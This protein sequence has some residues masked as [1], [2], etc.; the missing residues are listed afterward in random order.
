MR[1]GVQLHP[2][3][4]DYADIRRALIEA[5][6]LGVDIVYNWDHFYPLYGEPDGKHF[7]AW[8]ML[9]SWAE[10]TERVEIGPLVTCN[11]YR[12]PQLLADMARTVDHVSE[13]RLILGLGSGWFERDYTEYG[14]EFGT[15][16]GRLRHLDAN[17]PLIKERL[18]KLNP[19]PMRDIPIL[20]GG[21]GE[22]VTL[23]IVAEHADI[24]HGFFDSKKPEQYTHKNRVLNDWCATVG[25]DP[26]AI[27][28]S[29]GVDPQRI[30]VADQLIEGGAQQVTLGFNGPG[31]D[32]SMVAEWL[33]WRDQMNAA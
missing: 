27:E 16:G 29:V 30:D 21:G 18:T 17:L 6:E 22:K 10:I 5:E 19:P 4:A 31:F 12:N 9:A 33:A 8:T 11:S 24:W 3:H 15:A 28:R 7:E 1:I 13:G 20:I 32:M 14:Y 25:R 26:A 23:R 2:Q